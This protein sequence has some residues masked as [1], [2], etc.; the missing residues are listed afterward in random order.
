[1][2]GDILFYCLQVEEAK[3]REEEHRIAEEARRA[4]EEEARR[5][6][7][8]RQKDEARRIEESRRQEEARQHKVENKYVYCRVSLDICLSCC[9]DFFFNK[10]ALCKVED[11][12]GTFFNS[13]FL[14]CCSVEIFRI[15]VYNQMS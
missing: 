9:R 13:F 1:M 10:S 7:E 4:A 3:R 6:E 15:H 8:A 2:S 5:V 12:K 11:V 14:N